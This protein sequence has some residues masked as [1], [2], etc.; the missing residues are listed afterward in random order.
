MAY[1]CHSKKKK[2][3]WPMVAIDQNALRCIC[4]QEWLPEVILGAS[5]KIK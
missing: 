2:G 4:F 1:R 3:V 5:L